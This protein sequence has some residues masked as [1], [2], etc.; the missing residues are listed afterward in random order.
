M[1]IVGSWDYDCYD[2][3]EL[4][5]MQAMAFADA[6]IELCKRMKQGDLECTFLHGQAA[7]YLGFHSTELFLK[8]AI[9]HKSGELITGHK[10]RSLRKRYSELYPEE[11]FKIKTHYQVHY[12]GYTEEEV[13][14]FI[15][16]E[17]PIDQKLR[18]PID[19]DKSKWWQSDAFDAPTCLE[20]F[21]HYR[22]AMEQVGQ[23]IYINKC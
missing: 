10:L 2:N 17:L 21:R 19:K 23:Q 15:K 3:A 9:L 8:A 22:K 1:E 14:H 12:M 7:L 5:H 18:Y 4:M 11:I 16:K 20:Q 13:A 6:A